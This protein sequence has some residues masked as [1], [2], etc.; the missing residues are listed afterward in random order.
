MPHPPADEESRVGALYDGVAGLYEALYPS[1][2]HYAERVASFL[3]DAVFPHARVLDV[4]CGGGQ[5]TR[6]LPPSVEVVGLDLSERMLE[7]ARSGRPH[8]RY[9]QHSY[10]QPLPATL[11]LF[12]VALAAGCLDFCSDLEGTLG[13]LAAALRPG[14][15]LLF[16]VLERRFD[17]PGHE[18]PTRVLLGAEPPVTLHFW[19]RS[20]CEAAIARAGLRVV[21]TAHAFAFAVESEGLRLHYRWWQVRR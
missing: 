18:S 6:N 17:L 2:H 21:S 5:L 8:G 19:S 12:D 10:A 1:L 7:V 9:L 14:G 11:G 13:N 16:S 3:A 4:G 15:R 20:G